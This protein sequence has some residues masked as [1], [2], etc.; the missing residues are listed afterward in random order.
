M[1]RIRAILVGAGGG[2]I[3]SAGLTAALDADAAF[4][5]CDPWAQVGYNAFVA[6]GNAVVGAITSSVTTIV[7]DLQ[8]GPMYNWDQGMGQW[9]QELGK[10][11]ASTRALTEGKIAAESQLYIQEKTGDAVMATVEAASFD[12][13]I[14]SALMLGDQDV[15]V[16][17]AVREY[18]RIHADSLVS[19]RFA[20]PSAAAVARHQK[21][22][23]QRQVDAGVCA[24]AAAPG[25]E[26]ADVNVASVLNPIAG[27][28]YSDEGRQA[29]LD[30]VQNVVG[31][32]H[33]RAQAGTDSP[34]AR[35]AD[36]LTIADQ[37]AL[38]AAAYSLNSIMAER[39]RRLETEQP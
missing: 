12:E 25:M 35:A 24:Q 20:S 38:S 31:N 23:S 27:K 10:Q 32:E 3:L 9:L 18:G 7:T 26:Y 4:T 29:A 28:T 19:D 15:T 30:Y 2:V 37:A 17:K 11:T 21:W 6:A 16:R 34:Q 36:A 1:S 33:L 5:C 14:T 8:T 39:T 22:C 13:T